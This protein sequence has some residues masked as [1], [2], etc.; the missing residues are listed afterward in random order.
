MKCLRRN[1]RTVQLFKRL[2]IDIKSIFL[3]SKCDSRATNHESWVVSHGH[4]LLNNA[5]FTCI[6]AAFG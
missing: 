5:D 6:I 1:Q 4:F 3:F 2:L